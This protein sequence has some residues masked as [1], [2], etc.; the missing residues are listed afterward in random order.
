MR[1]QAELDAKYAAEEA[2]QAE[3]NKQPLTDEM[4]AEID[5]L[6]PGDQYALA[7]GE[8]AKMPV[9]AV[10]GVDPQRLQ[11]LT[12]VTVSHASP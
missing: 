4:R 12:N 5:V 2:R 6:F 9:P 3:R 1:H 11:F 10:E 8:L 7:R